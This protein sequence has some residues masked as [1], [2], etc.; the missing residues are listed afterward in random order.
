MSTQY[1]HCFSPIT[2]R[3]V[4]F[5]NRI[6]VAPN[7]PGMAT[8]NGEVTRE[9][10]E[11][12]RAHARG[13]AGIVT[14]G[15]ATVNMAAGRDECKMIDLSTNH[16]IV[17][18]NRYVEAIEQYGAVA[19]IEI[20]HC[21]RNSIPDY[22]GPLE[23]VSAS[24]IIGMAELGRA[25]ME[26]RRPYSVK[27]LSTLEVMDLVQWFVDAAVRCQRAGFRMIM[28]HGGHNNLI[29]Q[30]SSPWSNKRTDRYGGS[31][32]NRA[33]FAREI[34]LG[35]R[36]KCG[37]RLV[38]EYRIS[39][40]ELTPEG[41]HV[42]E[43]I[44]LAK[45]LEPWVDIFNISIGAVAEVEIVPKMIQPTYYK[46]MYLAD[47]ARQFKA[48][49]K[50]AKI[51][52]VGSVMNLDNA[53]K[54]LADGWADF[55]L[56]MRPF[57]ADPELVRKSAL[58]KQDDICPCIRCSYH[59]RILNNK[60]VGCAVNP[61][62][63][64]EAEFPKGRIE[65]ADEKK[66]VL[67]VGGGPAGMEAAITA[68]QRGHEVTLCEKSGALGGNLVFG[69]TLSMKED[70]RNYF[71]YIVRKTK[72]SGAEIRLNTEVKPELV[73]EMKPDEMIIAVGA[74]QIVPNIPGIHNRNVHLVCEADGGK[75]P[76]GNKIIIVGA[77]LTGCESAVHFARLGKDVTVIEMAGPAGVLAGAGASGIA[78]KGIMKELGAKVSPNTKLLEV[79]ENGIRCLNTV[80]SDF[81]EMECD[82]VLLS[83]GCRSNRD[84]VES[85]RHCIPETEVYVVGDA[86][87]VA[88]VGFA[89]NAAFWA[90]NAI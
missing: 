56:M 45:L 34:L 83:V 49:L 85:L 2:I 73:N 40:D 38:I 28:L 22:T 36:E 50:T 25:K 39:A 70:L 66:K 60:V 86:K 31:L 29:G 52:A 89:V 16:V 74:T 6:G 90:A 17:G 71:D 18:L 43:S 13:G 53:E 80:T 72:R 78:L 87:R 27:D 81:C 19:S 59:S 14:I 24:P 46:H 4:E 58:G 57:M 67:I 69:T 41:L 23:T 61:M 88:N 48:E 76:V 42:E 21:G 47:Y 65:P 32:E 44:R 8:E 30:F 51:S 82:T 10:I 3:G 84:T 5:K 75:K 37:E 15:N 68:R 26:G 54:I 7:V 55:V 20:N 63:G 64:H 35:I 79:T 62:C 77:G 1:P 33:R 12:H 9:L 11:Y